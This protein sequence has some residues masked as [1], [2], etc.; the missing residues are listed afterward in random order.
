MKNNFKLFV[1]I[2]MVAVIG[3][4]STGCATP[5]E[6]GQTGRI[7]RAGWVYHPNAPMKDYVVVGTIVL[8]NQRPATVLAALMNRAIE[9]G[10]HDIIH[11]R[12]ST[13]EYRRSGPSGERGEWLT[14][15]AVVIRYTDETI[16]QESLCIC[17][18][19]DAGFR[20]FGR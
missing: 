8:T 9:M 3:L 13:E 17:D 16:V 7:H 10:G 15:T 1:I 14:A 11:V 2:A 6:T 19:A 4:F 20:L 5:A 12:L 18:H